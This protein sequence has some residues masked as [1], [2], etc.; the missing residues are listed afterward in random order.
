[1]KGTHELDTEDVQWINVAGNIWR[2]KPTVYKG[3]DAIHRTIVAKTP[4]RVENVEVRPLSPEVAVAVAN[5][6]RD[7]ELAVRSL[8]SA[9]ELLDKG[10]SSPNIFQALVACFTFN[11]QVAR[12]LGLF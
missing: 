6:Q 1:M 12:E 3:H 11:G 4:M 10:F 2:G 5:A 7:L 9:E 8:S